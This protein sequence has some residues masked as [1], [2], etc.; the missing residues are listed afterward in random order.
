[1]VPLEMEAVDIQLSQVFQNPRNSIDERPS[2][3]YER[4]FASGALR[5]TGHAIAPTALRIVNNP[6][7]GG[8]GALRREGELTPGSLL[9]YTSTQERSESR[10]G[11]IGRHVGLRN[12]C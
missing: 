5:R 8:E 7:A 11:E 1:M 4:R 2:T 10:H 9:C 3:D 12:Q 6:L